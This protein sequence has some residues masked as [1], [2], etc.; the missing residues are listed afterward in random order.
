M[1]ALLPGEVCAAACAAAVQMG[2]QERRAAPVRLKLWLSGS[3]LP[4]HVRQAGMVC[5]QEA[6]ER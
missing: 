6:E 4:C 5:R 1:P 3:P 2:A